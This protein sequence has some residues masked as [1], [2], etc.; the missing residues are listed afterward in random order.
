MELPVKGFAIDCITGEERD[1]IKSKDKKIT[2]YPNGIIHKMMIYCP[3]LKQW[4]VLERVSCL[5]SI[6]DIKV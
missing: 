6:F 1:M 2:Y 5:P 3:I 4:E